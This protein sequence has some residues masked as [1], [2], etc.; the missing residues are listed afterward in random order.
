VTDGAVHFPGAHPL[1][2]GALARA[3]DGAQ[4]LHFLDGRTAH[5]TGAPIAEVLPVPEGIWSLVRH[6][7]DGD[8]QSSA[9]ADEAD[10]CLLPSTSRTHLPARDRPRRLASDFTALA[11]GDLSGATAA[12][13]RGVLVLR[14]PGRGPTTLAALHARAAA[15]H[16]GAAE[17][18]GGPD[19][20]LRLEWTNHRHA[21]V[22]WDSRLARPEIVAG[23]HGHDAPRELDPAAL[24][25]L[26][27]YLRTVDRAAALGFTPAPGRGHAP[28][29]LAAP[30]FAD[31]SPRERTARAA[32]LWDL[33]AAHADRHH[34]GR[35]APVHLAGT[36]HTIRRGRLE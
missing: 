14:A 23:G 6:D 3:S 20:D 32:V 10:L 31:L 33:L 18:A 8:G 24:A 19:L 5:F 27:D 21:S 26:D 29:R 35:L 16:R 34:H 4:F 30:G 2:G 22:S 12:I 9:L 28:P 36:A 13:E 1:P 25:D 15:V 7:T 11:V 17:L